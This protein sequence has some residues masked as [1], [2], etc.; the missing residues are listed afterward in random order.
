MYSADI[1]NVLFLVPFEYLKMWLDLPWMIVLADFRQG[2]FLCAMAT[3][4]AVFVGEHHSY[5]N[6]N[7]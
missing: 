3:F 6:V 4:W 1:W 5:D 7:N 2:V